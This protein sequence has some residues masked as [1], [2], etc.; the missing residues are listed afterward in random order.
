[1]KFQSAAAFE[2]HLKES[3][4]DHLSHIFLFVSPCHYEKRLWI[5]AVIEVLK[6]KDPQL[7]VMHFQAPETAPIVVQDEMRTPTL[8]GGTRLLIVHAIDKVKPIGAY[9]DLLNYHSPDLFLVFCA[10]AAKPVAELYQKGK[11]EIVA[12]D[13]SEEKPWDRERRL[14]EWLK[15]QARKVGK[16]LS[17]NVAAEILKNLGSDLA[18]LD[19]ELKK[20]ITYVGAKTELTLNDVEAIC[21]SKDLLTGWNLAETLV[22]KQPI[23]V[24]GKAADL[25]FLF[26]FLGQIRYH[27]QLG[28]QLAELIEQKVSMAELKHYFPAVRP[29]NLDK[30]IPIATQRGSLFFIQGILKLYDFELIAKSSS[31]DLTISFDL[32]QAKL[33]EKTH[34][35]S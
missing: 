34:S 35:S 11:K 31:L 32:F 17:S 8:W 14:Q 25:G 7:Q 20:L 4:P 30:F 15:D 26:P 23:A 1:M 24:Q 5:E 10:E 2:K 28:A 21:G 18:A 16:Q 13:V 9:L 22:W 33:Y 27:L 6:K 3:F 19:Q 29:Q 12:L